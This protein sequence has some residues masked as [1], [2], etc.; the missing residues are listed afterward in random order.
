MAA[1][2]ENT[3]ITRRRVHIQSNFERTA[4][5]FM[6]ISGIALLILAVGHMLLQHVLNSSTNLTIMF[7]A[8]QWNTWG[9]KLFDFLLLLFTI[10][11]GINGLRNVLED[12]IHHKTAMKTINVFLAIFVVA[13]LIWAGYAIINFDS[14][15]FMN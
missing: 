4:F 12:Y 14:T 15:P 9:W 13:T 1:I 6:R 10:P 2:S 11:H 3:G 5:L 8:E 7:V